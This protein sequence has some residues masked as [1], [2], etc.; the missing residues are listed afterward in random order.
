VLAPAAQGGKEQVPVLSSQTKPVSEVHT[1]EEEAE[2]VVPQEQSL[3]PSVSWHAGNEH[4]LATASHIKPVSAW[5]TFFPHK[6]AVFVFNDVLSVLSQISPL[7][8]QTHS[9]LLPQ[10]SLIAKE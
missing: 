5:Q 3:V 10:V 9:S 4:A 1:E 8:G 2:V 7:K 6:H